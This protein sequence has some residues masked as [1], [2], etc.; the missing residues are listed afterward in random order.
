MNEAAIAPGTRS[1][2]QLRHCAGPK[3]PLH[4]ICEP[5]G[6]LLLPPHSLLVQAPL[7]ATERLWGVRNQDYERR[8][9]AVKEQWT[10]SHGA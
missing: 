1:R 2:T 5:T 10:Q 8:A 6:E 4:D 9:S 7:Q 3:H